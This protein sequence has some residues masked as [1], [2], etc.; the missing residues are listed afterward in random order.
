MSISEDGVLRLVGMVYDAALDEHKWP[1]FLEA[2]AHAV[3]GASAM[4]R[5]ADWQAGKAGFVTSTGYEPAWQSAYCKHFVKLDYLTPFLN[6]FELGE[7]KASDAQTQ[8]G[9]LM[10]LAT[11]TLAHCREDAIN[12]MED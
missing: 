2:F 6:Q 4:L 12:V 1:T 7:V 9:L 10:L 3:G 5:S 11:G 8:S